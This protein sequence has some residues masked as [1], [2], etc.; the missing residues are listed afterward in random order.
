MLTRRC[1]VTYKV[2]T[3]Q[4]GT[5]FSMPTSGTTRVI[6]AAR[7]ATQP[8]CS[9][10]D[11]YPVPFH[12]IT[13]LLGRAYRVLKCHPKQGRKIHRFRRALQCGLLTH[14]A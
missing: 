10:Q 7:I 9:I 4:D 12:S 13:V 1:A 11:R 2:K 5:S 14:E 3:P 6:Q 8:P